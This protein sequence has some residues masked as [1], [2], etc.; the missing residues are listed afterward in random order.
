M[1]TWYH[2]IRERRGTK[3]NMTN[4]A[5]LYFEEVAEKTAKFANSHK[6]SIKILFLADL[7]GVEYTKPGP[8]I[9]YI[10]RSYIKEVVD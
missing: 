5:R 7:A 2:Y 9:S 4:E 3:N 1:V 6:R 10:D 8:V